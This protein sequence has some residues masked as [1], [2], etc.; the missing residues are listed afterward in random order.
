LLNSRVEPWKLVFAALAFNVI[1]MPIAMTA[2]AL[3]TSGL[4]ESC[5]TLADNLDE[6]GYVY[7]VLSYWYIIA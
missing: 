2:A 5:K 6:I 1:F 7:L 4:S 3:T